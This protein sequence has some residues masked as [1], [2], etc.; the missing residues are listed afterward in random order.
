MKIIS[1]NIAHQTKLWS[2]LL[3]IDADIALLQEACEPPKE[4][5]SQLDIG[6]GPWE[7]DG[8]DAKR[9]WKTAIVGLNPR[10]RLDRIKT[11]PI[12]SGNTGDFQVSCAGTIEIANVEH[13]DSGE[14]LTV[15]SM[16]APWERPNVSTQSSWIYADASVH[17]LISDIS[18]LVGTQRNHRILA[19]GDLNILY[20]YGEGGSKYWANRYQTVFDRFASMG[21]V[22]VGP[23][24][25]NGIQA[26][27]WPL[28]L[29]NTSLNVP[30]FR[31]HRKTPESATRQLDFVFASKSIS[32]NVKTYAKNSIDDWG[33]SDHCR[34]HVELK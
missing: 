3:G 21:L 10:V 1:W 26:D 12:N 14:H 5:T 24:Y 2:E 17:R 19:A 4:I 15:I 27:P 8:A 7:T 25:P 16:Y 28:E 6:C 20:G 34:I 9:P 23:Q 30:T 32:Q 29:P 13:L 18:A 31:T 33:E 22:F 11:V